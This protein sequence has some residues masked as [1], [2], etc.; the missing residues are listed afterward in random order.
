MKKAF[1]SAA[2]V[3][4]ALALPGAPALAQTNEITIGITV[5]TTGPAAALGIPE[6]NALDFVP[7]EIGGVPIKV[8]VLDDGGDPD[9]GD[10]Q[11]AAVRDRIQGRHHHGLLDDA[12]DGRGFDRCERGG[13]SAFRPGA[14][15]DQRSARQVVGGHAAADPDHGQ[16]AVRAHEGA[17]HQDR[18]LYRLLRFLRRSLDE[19]LQGPGHSDGIDAWR[20][21]SAL[22]V[23]IP[24]SPD[25]C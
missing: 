23:R 16:G 14:V 18:R 3:A 11:C 4:A 5:T 22:P 10:H 24:R 13:D 15:P 7:K 17:R 20:P 25:R 1:L 8:I 9:R 19:R 21:K 6:R 2:A 12:A